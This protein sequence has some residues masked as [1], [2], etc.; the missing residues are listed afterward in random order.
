MDIRIDNV[1]SF[2]EGQSF[3]KAGAYERLKGVA[4]GKLD[5][6]HPQNTC[7]VDLDKAPR[8][9][10]G[11][12]EYEIDLEILRPVDPARANGVV[13]YEVTNRGNKLIGRLNGVVPVN[14]LNPAE[15]NDPTIAAHAGTGF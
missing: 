4:R 13:L 12:V 15:L 9:A 5:P 11:L 10:Q 14:P 6:S 7:I 8:N 2:A 3:G 1:R